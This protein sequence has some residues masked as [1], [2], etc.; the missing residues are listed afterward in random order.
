M[1]ARARL[2]EER[3]RLEGVAGAAAGGLDAGDERQAT[4]ELSAVDQ[5]PADLGTETFNRE[6][7]RSIAESVAAELADIDD[8]LGRLD[9]GTYGCCQSCGGP[10]GDERLDVLPAARFCVEHER[11][12]EAEAASGDPVAPS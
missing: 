2:L 7:D 6:A 12:A 4:S 8:A 1:D 5:H 9:A 10:I 3:R 11:M